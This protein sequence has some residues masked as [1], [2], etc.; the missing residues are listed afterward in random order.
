MEYVY[1]LKLESRALLK[2]G[3]ARNLS[4]VIQHCKSYGIDIESSYRFCPPIH[5]KSSK[6]ESVLLDHT[7]EF[8]PTVDVLSSLPTTDGV[9]EIRNSNS[10]DSILHLAKALKCEITKGF[11]NRL[12]I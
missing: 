10:L 3:M 1:V 12:V 4:R 5:L 9:S 6:L 8:K 11:I 7:M 2:I